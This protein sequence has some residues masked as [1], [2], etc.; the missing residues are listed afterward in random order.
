MCQAQVWKKGVLQQC[1]QNDDGDLCRFHKNYNLEWLN[2]N[3]YNQIVFIL[4]LAYF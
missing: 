3:I 4:F 2:F 1:H